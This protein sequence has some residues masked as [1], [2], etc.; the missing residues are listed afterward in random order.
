MS[1]KGPWHADYFELKTMKAQLTREEFFLLSLFLKEIQI[2]K[3]VSKGR[4][5]SHLKTLQP[6]I[7]QEDSTPFS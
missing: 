4:L 2:Q 3:P 5:D 1:L 7:T 6:S